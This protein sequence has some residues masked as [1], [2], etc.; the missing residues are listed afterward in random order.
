MESL[1]TR[2]AQPTIFSILCLLIIFNLVSTINSAQM[3]TEMYT[4]I[5]RKLLG[6]VPEKKYPIRTPLSNFMRRNSAPE[7]PLPPITLRPNRAPP[8]APPTS[9]VLQVFP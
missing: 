8:A 4:N 2:R 7:D 6:R 9:R 5:S 1:T 3:D